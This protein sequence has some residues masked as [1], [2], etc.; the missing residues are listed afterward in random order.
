MGNPKALNSDRFGRWTVLREN[1]RN[2]SGGVMWLCMCDC[3]TI[4]SVEGRSLRN[5]LSKSCGCLASEHRTEAARIAVTKHGGRN[6]RLYKVWLGILGRCQNPTN[7]HYADYGGRGITVCKEWKDYAA[8]REWALLTGYDPN[9]EYGSC[10]IDR[11]DNNAGYSPDN[12]RWADSTTQC[13]NRRSNH[14]VEYNGES[15]TI[16]EWARITGIRK[17]TLRRRIFIYGWDIKRAL[18]EHTHNYKRHIQ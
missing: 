14:F 9:A 6:E 10:T 17:D 12:C 8:F 4:R 7:R 13:N 5:G 3:G 18:T 2:K 15:H 11:I 16:T 1:G